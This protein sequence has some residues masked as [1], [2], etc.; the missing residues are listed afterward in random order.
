MKESKFNVYFRE[1]E[2]NKYVIFN[3]RTTALVVLDKREIDLYK[4]L[5]NNYFSYT[6]KDELELLNGLKKGGFILEDDVDEIGMLRYLQKVAQNSIDS[7]SLTIAPTMA[8]NFGCVYCY[9]GEHNCVE[10]MNDEVKERII[11]LVA[12]EIKKISVLNITWYGGEPLLEMDV[13]E[14]LSKKFIELCE[15]NNVFYT[16]SIITNGYY[17]NVENAKKLNDLKIEMVQVTLDGIEEYHDK[18]RP[19]KNGGGTFEKI[20]SNLIDIKG[21]LKNGISLRI[22]TDHYN[23]DSV[24]EVIQLLREYDL[25]ND[26]HPYLGHVDATNDFYDSKKCLSEEEFLMIRDDFRKE[27]SKYQNGN[28]EK[29]YPIV[30]LNSCMADSRGGLVIDPKGNISKCWCDI[31][32]SEYEIG[33]IKEGIK[34]Y[35][36]LI[37]YCNYDVFSDEKCQGCNVIP[38]CLGG[39]PKRRV[40]NNNSNCFST[41]K[42]LYNS[43]IDKVKEYDN[44]I[45]MLKECYI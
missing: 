23:K 35:D 29:R 41:K 8:C 28:L 26:I 33:N 20:I 1:E 45:V 32:Y 36:R 40:E 14:E 3:S 34:N 22:N 6:T 13:I 2:A 9:E 12:G 5:K 44:H 24:K 25:L 7:L 30:K 18:K 43:I 37:K 42:Q 31:G 10:I 17:L 39:C 4:Y 38:L 15:K 27:L 19:L 16:A 21:I 11:G